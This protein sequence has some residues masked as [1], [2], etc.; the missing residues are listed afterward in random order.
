MLRGVLGLIAF[1]GL[2]IA[3]KFRWTDA[4]AS[5]GKRA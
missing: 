1:A 5:D 4:G 3:A 2:Y